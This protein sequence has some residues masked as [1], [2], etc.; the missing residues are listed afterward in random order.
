MNRIYIADAALSGF[1]KSKDSLVD[2]IREA[3]SNL[4]FDLKDI[5]AIFLGLMNPEGFLGV[6]NIASYV[7]D[8]LGLSG[9]PAV[10]VETAS[11]TGA[12]VLFYAYATL[13]SGIYKNVLVLA[14]EKMTHLDTPRTT[15]LI[16]EVIDPYERKIGVS[17]PSLAAMVTN[18]FAYEN[19]L[20]IVK[21]QNLLFAVA[22]KNHYYGK[23]NEYAQ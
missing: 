20:N 23:F 22:E 1:G 3:V 2:I 7:A 8:K 14:A 10:R 15:K 6:G 16:A 13:A 11:S 19:K 21:L 5:D 12:A 9:K 18:R 4:N 17:M